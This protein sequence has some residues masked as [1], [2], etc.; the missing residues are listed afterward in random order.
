LVWG[1]W[2]RR[3]SSIQDDVIRDTHAAPSPWTAL[4]RN[5]SLWLLTISY[6]CIGYV[7]YLL[8]YWSEHYFNR[9]LQ[10]SVDHSRLAAMILTL[11]MGVSMPLGGWLSDRLLRRFGYRGSRARVAV[12]GITACGLLLALGTIL[13]SGPGIVACFALA[14]GGAGIAEAPSWAT[15][16]DL[17][18]V[19]G[20]SSAAIVNTGGNGVGLLAPV[21]TP[22][23]AAWLT[24]SL[25]AEAAWAWGMR[26][27]SVICLFGA[28][29]WIWI[30]AGERS[31]VLPISAGS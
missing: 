18:G 5:R 23:V 16:I 8:F 22:L 15:A 19:R 30:D 26:L 4:L 31:H 1:E 6:G 24:S 9:V 14:L 10:F 11:T 17:G 25:G 29:L 20:G 12:A 3:A 13:S 21:V 7:E 2:Q 27:A 28:G